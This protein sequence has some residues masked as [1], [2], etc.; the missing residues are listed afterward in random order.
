MAEPMITVTGTYITPRDT[1]ARGSIIFTPADV[2]D[3]TNAKVALQSS[4]S[5]ALDQNGQINTTLLQTPGGYRV[6][7]AIEGAPQ[8]SY[9]ISGTASTDLSS[10]NADTAQFDASGIGV[11]PIEDIVTGGTYTSVLADIG[12]LKRFIAIT[13]L[14]FN[15]NGAINYPVGGAFDI[16]NWSSGRVHLVGVNGAVLRQADNALYLRKQYSGCTVTKM[17][18]T[19][20]WV[21]GDVATS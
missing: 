19:E 15:V 14:T 13:E 10:V 16:L 9:V 4:V 11:I 17:T 5:I 8:V 1:A 7:E 21:V 18:N 2:R 20:F 6:T 3:I 12:K